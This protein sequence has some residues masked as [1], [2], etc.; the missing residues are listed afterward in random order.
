[1]R[2]SGPGVSAAC[3]P[4]PLPCPWPLTAPPHGLLTVLGP[5]LCTGWPR[6]SN[7]HLSS[8]HGVTL[9]GFR[10]LL[11]CLLPVPPARSGSPAS[12]AS[13]LFSLKSSFLGDHYAH[14]L[15]PK[16]G[17]PPSVL[18]SALLSAPRAALA[19]SRGSIN[20]C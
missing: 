17:A 18:F 6:V 2:S 12:P 16:A 19:H 7:V 4:H 20:V 15:P 8:G 14:C 9:T 13:A 3:R 1:M 10:T 5:T 11:Q